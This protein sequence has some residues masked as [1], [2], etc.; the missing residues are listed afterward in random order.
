MNLQQPQGCGD[1][2]PPGGTSLSTSN[3]LSIA[4]EERVWHLFNLGKVAMFCCQVSVDVCVGV[5]VCS[6]IPMQL[7]QERIHMLTLVW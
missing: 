1:G 4:V 3:W 6:I 2:R 7:P 5:C